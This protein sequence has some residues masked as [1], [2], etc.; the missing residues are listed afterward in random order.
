MAEARHP[1]IGW[2]SDQAIAVVCRVS[3]MGPAHALRALT[4]AAALPSAVPTSLPGPGSPKKTGRGGPVVP[5][6]NRL[7]FLAEPAA[8]ECASA[9]AKSV[10]LGISSHLPERLTDSV[11]I[12][13]HL[14]HTDSLLIEILRNHRLEFRL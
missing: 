2:Q 8:A 5:L 6:T 12:R 10:S 11:W 1:D 9:R 3:G 7:P 13:N 4:V 14:Y